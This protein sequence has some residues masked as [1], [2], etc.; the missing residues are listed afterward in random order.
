[1]VK[2]LEEAAEAL[3]YAHQRGLI[4]LDVK[5]ANLLLDA[6]GRLLLA[7]FG[8]SVVLEG[9]THVSLHYYVGTP[10]YT[11]P[12]Q[13]LEQPRPASDQ[14]A[15]AVTC[16][17]LL[18]GRPPFT[19]SLYAVMHGHLQTPVPPPGMLNPLI[20]PA[21]E[22]V[23]QR[24]LAKDPTARYPG[25][26]AFASAFRQALEQPAGAHTD[27]PLAPS[28][29][30]QHAL[31]VFPLSDMTRI[32][33]MADNHG[34]QEENRA[35]TAS[36]TKPGARRG[37]RGR[38]WPQTLLLLEL[39]LLLVGA[40]SLGFVRA[41]QPC[42]LGICPQIL[43]STTAITLIND[44]TEV[45]I[46]SNS[47]ASD[48]HWQARVNPAHSWLTLTPA[49]GTLPGGK[50][51]LLTIR[52]NVD[53]LDLT[54]PYSASIDLSGDRGA[55]PQR[56]SVT[57]TVTTGLGQIMVTAPR[58]TS[59]LYEQGRLQPAQQAITLTNNSARTLNWYISSTYNNWLFVTPS[60]GSVASGQRKTL[61]VTVTN[62]QQLINDTYQ[63]RLSLMGELDQKD[64]PQLLQTIDFSLQVHQTMSLIPAVIS[65]GLTT[66]PLSF[67]A[68]PVHTGDAPALAYPHHSIAWD[69]QD[70]QQ[71]AFSG[72]DLR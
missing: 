61:N 70:N 43:L 26:L 42:W 22:A 23:L 13:W 39:V 51:R 69:A 36:H 59:F 45:I 9:Y 64:R 7:D 38:H 6:Q 2:Y 25:I 21:V 3:H 18:T 71:L 30:E 44:A 35:H 37:K 62:P 12:E 28:Q 50:S 24:A 56:I 40:S 55:L 60:Q 5:P 4:H 67:V 17:Q 14:Y 53:R 72:I 54:G 29:Q 57:E 8:V 49:S 47:G 15:L 52:T 31:Q 10:L 1:M 20:S 58:G 16:Y 65:P 66:S 19:G 27:E 48:L 63:V 46:L 68:Q 33:P 32:L 34:L 11:A 41:L